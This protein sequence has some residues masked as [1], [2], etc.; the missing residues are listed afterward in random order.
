V[1]GV[2]TLPAV[3]DRPRRALAPVTFL[4]ALAGVCA[5]ATAPAAHAQPRPAKCKPGKYWLVQTDSDIQV[6]QLDVRGLPRKTSDYAPRCLVADALAGLLQSDYE[7]RGRLRTKVTVM[8]ARW[9]A[10]TW[11]VRFKRYLDTQSVPYLSVTARRGRGR[12]T[13]VIYDITA[14]PEYPSVTWTGTEPV[15]ENRGDC[16]RD[17][18]QVPP[19]ATVTSTAGNE[20]CFTVPT[21]VHYDIIAATDDEYDAKLIALGVDAGAYD[22]PTDVQQQLRQADPNLIAPRFAVIRWPGGELRQAWTKCC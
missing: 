12:I 1:S 9:S 7:R 4:L 8:G 16:V 13:M 3:T 17:P 6:E 22:V 10:G 20:T 19:G 18:A 15:V 14:D 11:T 21:V 2:A 5:L